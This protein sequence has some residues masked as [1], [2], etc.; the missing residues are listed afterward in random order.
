MGLGSAKIPLLAPKRSIYVYFI[1]I[2]LEPIVCNLIFC[3]RRPL[4]SSKTKPGEKNTHVIY[5]N[6]ISTNFLVLC[7]RK[8]V[9]AYER[10]MIKIQNTGQ[11]NNSFH[12]PPSL[13]VG[14]LAAS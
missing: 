14:L 13:V 3:T 4:Q 6:C 10:K 2:Y 11:G 1:F 9:S 8:T 12:K 5:G 7:K